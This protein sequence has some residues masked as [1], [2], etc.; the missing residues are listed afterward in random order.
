[1]EKASAPANSHGPI[2]CFSATLPSNTWPAPLVPRTRRYT[3]RERLAVTGEVLIPL[4]EAAVAEIAENISNE[5][6]G[7]VAI[8]LLHAYAHDAHEQRVRELLRKHLPKNVTI[9]VSSEVAPEIR[10]YERFSTTVANAYVRPLMASYLYRLRDQMQEMKLAGPLFLSFA[11]FQDQA[12]QFGFDR[13]QGAAQQ[14]E[15]LPGLSGSAN[16]SAP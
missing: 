7:A 10:E 2:V 8:G 6:V 3:V 1:V 13:F 5:K 11:L 9:C 15:S 4:D 12:G 16:A 14:V